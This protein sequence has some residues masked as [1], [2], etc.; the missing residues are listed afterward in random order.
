MVPRNLHL[1]GVASYLT[2]AYLPGS[3]TLV[4]GVHELLPGK[5][6]KVRCGE[7]ARQR[8]W[9]V[10]P[11]P[12]APLPEDALRSALRSRLEKAVRRRLPAGEVVGTTLS[13]G[14]DSSLV[15]ALAC[16]LHNAPVQT[17]SVSFGPGHANGCPSVAGRRPLPHRAPHRR[18]SPLAV[19]HYLDESIALL[20]DPIGD[21]LTVPNALLF[22][23][24]AATTGVVLNGEGGDPCF[25]GPKNLPMLLAERT[26]TPMTAWPASAATCALT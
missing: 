16:R 3:D 12:D 1:P 4:S 25:G 19:L 24:A 13:G 5:V 23:E 10:P 15:V 11:E 8:L 20:S 2:Y 9:S 7:V 26:I 21:P 22:R 6:L 18:A 17:F 14:L